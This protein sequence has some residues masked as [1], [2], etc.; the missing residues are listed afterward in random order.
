MVNNNSVF[1]STELLE[2][3]HT[4]IHFG[5]IRQDSAM[6]IRPFFVICNNTP[7]I[8]WTAFQ[9]SIASLLQLSY[10]CI[11]ATQINEL[12]NRHNLRF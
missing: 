11:S 5:N 4:V 2:L 9:R 3:K 7:Q 8:N 12:R 10:H 1:M 6:L